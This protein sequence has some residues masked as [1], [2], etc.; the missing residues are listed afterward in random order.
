VSARG[1]QQF[2]A[3]C[4]VD[5]PFLDLAA[6]N[7][8]SALADFD[9]SEQ[10]RI[11]FTTLDLAHVRTFAG[12]VTKVQNNGLWSTFPTTRLLIDWYGL[13]L[14]LFTDYRSQHQHDRCAPD[15]S[16]TDRVRHF[17]DFFAAWVE[18]RSNQYL[19][20]LDVF[21]HER[22]LYGQRLALQSVDVT[23]ESVSVAIDTCSDNVI[24]QLV[25]EIRGRLD[26]ERFRYNITDL[27][28]AVRND[29]ASLGGLRANERYLA[30]W[31]DWSEMRLRIFEIDEAARALLLGVDGQSALADLLR[32][33]AG[34]GGTASHRN[35]LRSAM[36]DM[37]SIG[38]VGVR[39]GTRA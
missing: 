32:L 23:S 22:I 11:D 2:I 31:G 29:P 27:V 4:V 14:D 13:D 24:D 39:S 26:I 12:L 37:M 5:P 20:L 33:A 34:A 35:A 9:L 18:P 15:V 19:G 25:P 38:V 28:N 3:R 16:H 36:R 17:C 8:S 6:N 10:E 7:L 1:V 21:N 30:Y